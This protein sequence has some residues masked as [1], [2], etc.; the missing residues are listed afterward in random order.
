MTYQIKLDGDDD[1]VV[2]LECVGS[3]LNKIRDTPK[4]NEFLKLIEA[5][6]VSKLLVMKTTQLSQSEKQRLIKEYDDRIREI[7]DKFTCEI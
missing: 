7:G 1:Y 2:S 5:P 4:M 3:L 6:A